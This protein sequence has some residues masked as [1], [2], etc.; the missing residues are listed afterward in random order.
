MK[1]LSR[2]ILFLLVQCVALGQDIYQK[3]GKVLHASGLR[4]DGGVIF[5]RGASQVNPQETLLVAVNNVERIVFPDDPR[6][7]DAAASAYAGD[8]AAVLT[9]TGPLFS[10]ARQWAEIPGNTLP[11]V[12]RLMIPG[13]VASRKMSDLTRLVESWVPTNDPELESVV[14]LLKLKISGVDKTGFEN[15]CKALVL[16]TPGTLPAA[17]AWIELGY[18]ALEA[19]DWPAAIR[20]FASVRL[21]SQ[22]W[23]LLQPAALLGAIEACR[24]HGSSEQ[25]AP[26][27]TDLESEYP[28]TPQARIAKTLPPLTPAKK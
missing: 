24:G 6:L 2:L 23:R 10:Y 16:N 5:V 22:N 8:A 18:S 15:A 21:F 27:M 17:I 19:R 26:F 28:E 12:L 11:E 3:D 4:R 13:L 25:T 9:K 20:A 1:S 14:P 7:R